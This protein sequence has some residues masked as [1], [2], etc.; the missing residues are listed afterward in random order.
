MRERG[1]PTAGSPGRAPGTPTRS[2]HSAPTSLRPGRDGKCWNETTVVK[3]AQEG[4]EKGRRRRQREGEGN[5]CRQGRPA[6]MDASA[7]SGRGPPL[8]SPVGSPRTPLAAQQGQDRLRVAAQLTTSRSPPNA[9]DK[10]CGIRGRR[11]GPPPHSR[12]PQTLP[13][14]R[15]KAFSLC[16]PPNQS[17]CDH[18]GL[19]VDRLQAA[20]QIVGRTGR[21]DPIFSRPV[22]FISC[23]I[24]TSRFF[25][26]SLLSFTELSPEC[27]ICSSFTFNLFGLQFVF[28]FVLLFFY[29]DI[30]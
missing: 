29:G 3:R 20:G 7:S 6:A 18:A 28:Y 15:T 30:S 9:G 12:S 19:T 5:V 1:L 17:L 8:S 13:N 23:V 26:L 24:F 21:F 11:S 2:P 14:Q 27:L 22:F 10:D 16:H 25:F 4:G